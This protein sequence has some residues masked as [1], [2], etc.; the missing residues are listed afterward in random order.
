MRSSW[1]PLGTTASIQKELSFT[2]VRRDKER[3][4][5]L[6]LY[7]IKH[8]AV[9]LSTNVVSRWSRFYW[10]WREGCPYRE[11]RCGWGVHT[12]GKF[13]HKYTVCV[14]LETLP[15]RLRAARIYSCFSEK[16][17]TLEWKTVQVIRSCAWRVSVAV[18]TPAQGVNLTIR[19]SVLH[20]SFRSS[21]SASPSLSFI[22]SFWGTDLSSFFLSLSEKMQVYVGRSLGVWMNL[23][24][25]ICQEYSRLLFS[26]CFARRSLC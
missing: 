9:W 18:Y 20:A 19:P 5:S 11:K 24:V 4:G 2:D 10:F 25:W 1:P 26:L 17:K 21:S 7:L 13:S 6:F 14:S 3:K 23:G 22:L 8:F 15:K 12:L 16:R